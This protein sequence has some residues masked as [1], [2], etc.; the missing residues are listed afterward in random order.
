MTPLEEVLHLS[1]QIPLLLVETM[2]QDTVAS[3][4]PAPASEWA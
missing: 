4:C 2:Q 1:L 3:S